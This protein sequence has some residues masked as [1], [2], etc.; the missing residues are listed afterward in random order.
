[1]EV[2]YEPGT[3]IVEK[4]NCVLVVDEDFG[5]LSAIPISET[6]DIKSD[7]EKNYFP[8]A[9]FLYIKSYK[10]KIAYIG[11]IKPEFSNKSLREI[12][13]EN[14]EDLSKIKEY[15]SIIWENSN[16]KDTDKLLDWFL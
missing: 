10:D 16:Q 11:T 1:M 3:V 5:I 13:N 15:L 14:I 8:L 4:N 2:K 7:P 6:C 12:V 9:I